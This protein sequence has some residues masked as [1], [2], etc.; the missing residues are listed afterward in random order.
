[1]LNLVDSS[2]DR[3]EQ[4]LLD[5]EEQITQLRLEQARLL[6]QLDNQL[7]HRIDGARS[8]Q[9]WVRGRLDVSAHTARD[10]VDATR[11]L[12]AHS[13]PLDRRHG[14]SFERLVAT[15][16]LAATG[17]DGD[18]IRESFGHDLAGVDRLRRKQRRITRS[19]ERDRY[20]DRFVWFQDALDNT[21]GRLHGELPGFEYSI[22]RDA[23]EE[24]AERFGDLPGP[25]QTK[26]QRRA[27]ALV[28]I[29]QD[30]Q[31][32]INSEDTH[33]SRT[34]PLVTVFVDADQAHGYG[35]L[36]A[37][38]EFGPRVGPTVLDR[39]L[40]EGRVQLVGLENGKPVVTSDAA[41]AIPKAVS[42]FVKHRDGG[43]T[44]SG[45]HSRYRLQVH[46]IRFRSDGGD[47]HPD[48]LTTL[49]WFHHHVV[50]H[51]LGYQLDPDSPPH[52]RRFLRNVASGADPPPP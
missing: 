36:G 46:H 51:G 11:R 37:E 33:R 31:D 7:V 47:H 30:S 22:I 5:R 39:I 4:E 52:N 42:R 1:M 14:L 23:V 13:E 35:E 34:E 6:H 27:D 9:E 25:T 17:V 41:K 3:L 26:S 45:C 43:C 20:L 19:S 50:I 44:V 49:C 10:L 29:C 38:I 18:T 32:P 24:R 40:C 2:I 8:M 12:G 15:L 48:N 16:R 28:A 21:T